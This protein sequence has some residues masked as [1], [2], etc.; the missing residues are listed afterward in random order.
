MKTNYYE[1]A[2]ANTTYYVR[3]ERTTGIDGIA[4]STAM[5]YGGRYKVLDLSSG[6]RPRVG[7]CMFGSTATGRVRT[8]PVQSVKRITF[9]AFSTAP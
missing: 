9:R 4:R 1:V 6:E 7:G 3:I 2:T 8:S 5:A